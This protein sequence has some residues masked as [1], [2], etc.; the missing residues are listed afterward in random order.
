M[1][2]SDTVPYCCDGRSKRRVG[3]HL[4]DNS[5]DILS[6]K[7]GRL[8][9]AVP[10]HQV[11][12]CSFVDSLPFTVEFD[13]SHEAILRSCKFGLGRLGLKQIVILYVL[14]LEPRSLGAAYD[15]HFAGS[16]TA[17]SWRWM[18]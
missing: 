15:D 8:L 12:D 16:S 9:R 18:A 10:K 7:V 6:T 14:D 5:D 3:V 11:P 13:Y 4:R 17:D 2:Y 1:R